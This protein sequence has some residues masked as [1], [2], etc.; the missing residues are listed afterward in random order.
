MMLY[1]TVETEICKLVLHT[2]RRCIAVT[3]LY[4]VFSVS[5]YSSKYVA[6]NLTLIKIYYFF[7][8]RFIVFNII[9]YFS[10]S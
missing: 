4:I 5:D 8:I 9:F 3:D 6:V 2:V 1:G 7:R 10:M